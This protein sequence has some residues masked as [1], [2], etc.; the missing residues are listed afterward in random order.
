MRAYSPSRMFAV[1]LLRPMDRFS[2]A[3]RASKAGQ[4]SAS[5]IQHLPCPEADARHVCAHSA[6]V[7]SQL[8]FESS[9]SSI[10]SKSAL[11]DWSVLNRS[12]RSSS[13]S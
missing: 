8:A 13:N 12:C 3:S 6:V 4:S 7:T 9:A 1:A 11:I 2:C 10:A 5:S